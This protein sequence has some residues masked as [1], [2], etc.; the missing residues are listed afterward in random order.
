MD[1]VLREVV[2]GVA[3]LGKCSSRLI[4]VLGFGLSTAFLTT[5]LVNDLGG[6][7]VILRLGRD[8]SGE[9]RIGGCVLRSIVVNIRI[10]RRNESG[11]MGYSELITKVTKFNR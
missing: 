5:V 10:L 9:G 2:S 11:L 8:K 4:I 6:E 1:E 3:F 7:A